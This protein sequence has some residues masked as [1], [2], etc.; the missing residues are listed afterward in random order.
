MVHWSPDFKP[1]QTLPERL[2]VRAGRQI[3]SLGPVVDK[4][5]YESQEAMHVEEVGRHAERDAHR[6]HRREVQHAGVVVIR[7]D[8]Q[9]AIERPLHRVARHVERGLARAWIAEAS[10]AHREAVLHSMLF[11]DALINPSA[12]PI[13][14]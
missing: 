5:I 1:F 7:G 10:D 3:D 6:A 9:F 11:Y 2:A 8:V 14:Q 13:E 4:G 12:I